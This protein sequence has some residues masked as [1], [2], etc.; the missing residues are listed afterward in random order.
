MK[1]SG[2]SGFRGAAP[3]PGLVE[4]ARTTAVEERVDQRRNLRILEKRV[5]KPRARIDLVVVAS[6]FFGAGHVA[7]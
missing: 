5:A 3:L 6:A 4:L 1:S 7:V 2:D